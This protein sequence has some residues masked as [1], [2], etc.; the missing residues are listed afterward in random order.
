MAIA[1]IFERRQSERQS[2]ERP[3][4]VAVHQ[5]ERDPCFYCWNSRRAFCQKGQVKVVLLWFKQPKITESSQTRVRPA[6]WWFHR[7]GGV[8]LQSDLMAALPP[9]VNLSTR[10]KGGRSTPTT[11]Y[12][13]Y[14]L[15]NNLEVI[16]LRISTFSCFI[17]IL[18]HC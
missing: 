14:M 12:M 1:A 9:P 13:L 4:R 7:L 10:T 17:V 11:V 16:N 6:A 8:L 5:Q 2:E 15:R 3:L 18:Y